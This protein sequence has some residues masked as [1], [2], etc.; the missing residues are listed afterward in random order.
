MRIWLPV[1]AALLAIQALPAQAERDPLSGAPI[2]PSKKHETPSPITDRFYV[3]GTFFPAALQTSLR[4]DPHNGV[5][6]ALG[7]PVSGERD[8]GFDGR[9]PQGRI[10]LMFRMR[11]R[12]K[13]RVDYFETDRNGDRVLARQIV[14]GDQTFNVADRAT[15]SL[16][17]R[18]FTLAYTY[19]FVRNDRLEIGA[20]LAVHFLQADAR[21]AV[22]SRQVQQEVSGAGAFPTIPLDFAWRISR[23]FA[24]TARAQYFHASVNNFEGSVG[25]YHADVQY[26]WKPNFALGMGYTIMKWSLDVNDASF[27]GV[28]RLS[29][30]GPEAFFRVSF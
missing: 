23:R 21:A 6:G 19:S 10:E 25:D 17:W 9:T 11:S 5:P 15:S 18:A 13:L 1:A 7:T 12:S 16:D 24:L 27:P 28:F 22:A 29:A 3:R 30:S 14:F 4:V 2:R 20:G 26:R 8:L